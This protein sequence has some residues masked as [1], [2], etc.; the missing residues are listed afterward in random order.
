MW[1]QHVQHVRNWLMPLERH[2]LHQRPLQN[3]TYCRKT[4]SA[5]VCH[6]RSW[7][8]CLLNLALPKIY[9]AVSFMP[10]CIAPSSLC[11]LHLPMMTRWQV[12]G[13]SPES[14][15]CRL[16]CNN[17]SVGKSTETLFTLQTCICTMLCYASVQDLIACGRHRTSFS[18]A[19]PPWREDRAHDRTHTS[20]QQVPL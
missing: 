17:T 19:T 11:A 6:T 4:S 5:P 2:W 10:V 8:W 18:T 20:C 15:R 16:I 1:Q 12:P 13:E 9:D 7:H 3:C 14:N